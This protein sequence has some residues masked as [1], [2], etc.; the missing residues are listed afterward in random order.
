MAK[1][2][3]QTETATKTKATSSKRRTLLEMITG[4]PNEVAD[5]D[6]DAFGPDF[7]TLAEASFNE[8]VAEVRERQRRKGQDSPCAV[9]GRVAVKKPDGRVVFKSE[10]D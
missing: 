10:K 4:M 3:I 2:H 5:E 6:E 8:A 9:R 1:K 7:T